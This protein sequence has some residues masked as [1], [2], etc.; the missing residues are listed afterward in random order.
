MRSGPT[1]HS[2]KVVVV[3]IAIFLFDV[4]NIFVDVSQT[5]ARPMLRDITSTNA[6]VNK[7]NSSLR[8][9]TLC[10]ANKRVNFTEQG[11]VLLE[12]ILTIAITAAK[13]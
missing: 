10:M 12:G 6:R 11:V 13:K 4:R 5:T 7:S 9:G 3:R 1:S 2:V 8:Q